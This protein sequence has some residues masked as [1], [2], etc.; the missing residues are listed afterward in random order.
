M[1]RCKIICITSL[2]MVL[3]LVIMMTGCTPSDLKGTYVKTNDNNSS[4]TIVS[5][6]EKNN[7]AVVSVKNFTATSYGINNKTQ[8]KINAKLSSRSG[9]TINFKVSLDG[10]TVMGTL[11][12]KT[13]E[14]VCDG[15]TY[16]K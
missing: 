6:N 15:Q 8:E 14:I 7:E 1:K 2:L 9:D 3:V 16:K 5:I 4:I 12:W 13:A 11:N 10:N